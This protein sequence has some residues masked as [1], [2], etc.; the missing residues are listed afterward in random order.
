MAEENREQLRE[1]IEGERVE[2][3]STSEY[4]HLLDEEAEDKEDDQSGE[5]H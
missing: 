5:A 1:L 2:P 4:Q 3:R